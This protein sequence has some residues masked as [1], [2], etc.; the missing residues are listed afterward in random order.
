[1]LSKNL[2]AKLT[3]IYSNGK[4]NSERGNAY[5]FKQSLS[6]INSQKKTHITGGKILIQTY[7]QRETQ[8]QA[9][10]HRQTQTD[11]QTDTRQ[12]DRQRKETNRDKNNA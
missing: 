9:Q 3:L 11:R 10:R 12:T 7:T 1:M 6:K 2:D 4:R 8:I 5:Q